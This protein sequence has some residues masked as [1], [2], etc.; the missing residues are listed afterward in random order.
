MPSV[1]Y[2]GTTP[3]VPQNIEFS[4]KEIFPMQAL[5]KHIRNNRQQANK[6]GDVCYDRVNDFATYQEI[7]ELVAIKLKYRRRLS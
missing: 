1:A 3:L 7:F 2:T 6:T 4:K 5:H